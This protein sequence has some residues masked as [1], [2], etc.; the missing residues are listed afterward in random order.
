MLKWI[1]KTLFTLT[2]YP[3]FS[4]TFSAKTTRQ[5]LHQARDSAPFDIVI[6][7]GIPFENGK[8]DRIMKGR[9]YWSKY[10]FDQGITK[11]ILFSGSSVYSPY[12]EAKIMALYAEAIGIPE[13]HIFTETRAEHSTENAYY[14]Y[15]MAKQLGFR[16]IA[17]ASD[18]FQSK[19]L[20]GFIRKKVDKNMA[21]IPMVMDTMTAISPAM[22]DP[23]IA[24]QQTYNPDFVSIKDRQSWW[25]RL[26][27][28]LYGNIDTTMYSV[29]K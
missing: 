1:I 24:F 16:R 25:K 28:T 2:L 9:V 17:L 12:Y 11:N 13:K 22:I 4:C 19:L 23:V 5:L 20:K 27:G 29:G 15:K 6:V 10:L 21:V 18:P 26:N 3:L 14:G 8:W 7:P